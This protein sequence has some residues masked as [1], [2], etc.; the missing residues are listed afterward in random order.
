MVKIPSKSAGAQSG[1][2]SV[3][4]A[5][6]VLLGLK[7][8]SLLSCP[9][10]PGGGLDGCSARSAAGTQIAPN[11]DGE[12][13][14]LQALHAERSQSSLEAAASHVFCKRKLSRRCIK[15]PLAFGL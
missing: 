10:G 5:V 13:P 2:R 4:A 12:L 15:A 6:Q 3:P 7:G 11:F 1:T 8:Q 14:A 9:L